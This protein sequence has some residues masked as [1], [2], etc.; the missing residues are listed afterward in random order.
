MENVDGIDCFFS[1][2]FVAEDEIDPCRQRLPDHIRLKSL[3]V[4]Q[5]EQP[6]VI[7]TPRGQFD[8]VHPLTVLHQSKVEPCNNTGH[9]H[10]Q[11]RCQRVYVCIR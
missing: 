4:D 7:V 10:R 3:T 5:H 1:S 9:H 8:V 6:S 11:C 2:L